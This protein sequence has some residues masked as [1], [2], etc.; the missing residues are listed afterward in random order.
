MTYLRTEIFRR[1]FFI[2]ESIIYVLKVGRRRNLPTFLFMINI[3]E[4]KVAL[5]S[6]I[7]SNQP[8]QINNF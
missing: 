5:E 8:V 2:L 3:K 4:S 6:E 1:D 7:I